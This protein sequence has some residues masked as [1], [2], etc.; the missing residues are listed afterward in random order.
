MAQTIGT[1]FHQIVTFKWIRPKHVHKLQ[2]DRGC[3]DEDPDCHKIPKPVKRGKT[4]E[5]TVWI[6]Q[7][8]LC[9]LKK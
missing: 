2:F 3:V 6:R 8:K 4:I 5:R 9:N 7:N 1:N